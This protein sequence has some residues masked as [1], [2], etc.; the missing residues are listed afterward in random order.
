MLMLMVLILIHGQSPLSWTYP[1]SFS[2]RE[3]PSM[4]DGSFFFVNWSVFFRFLLRTKKES[5]PR[6]KKQTWALSHSLSL[7]S[8]VP[9]EC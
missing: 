9:Y 5:C 1:C 7:H 4:K 2:W 6:S 3:T 8:V